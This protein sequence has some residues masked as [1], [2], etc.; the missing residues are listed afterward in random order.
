FDPETSEYV[1][2]S[3]GR[4]PASPWWSVIASAQFC[5]FVSE[6]GG[7]TTWS[8]NSQS[9]RLTP[10]SNDAVCDPSGETVYLR[11]DEDLS[12]WSATPDPAGAGAEYVVRHGFGYT[13]FAHAR[14][15]L[16]H[17]FTVFVDRKRSAKVLHLA[18]TN[19]GPSARKISA[20]G[21][22]EWVL[23]TARDR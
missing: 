12:V 5:C 19:E 2:V 18:L 9:H 7:T 15:G 1:V 23:G 22:V 6:G 4:R 20:Y 17:V 14:G 3:A 11:D 16:R 10:W 8:T 21:A 13:S